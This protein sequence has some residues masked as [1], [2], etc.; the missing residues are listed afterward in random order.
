M[1]V[2]NTKNTLPVF[3][4]SIAYSNEEGFT[5]LT[6]IIQLFRWMKINA[7][8]EPIDIAGHN[9]QKKMKYGIDEG[10]LR[11][12]KQTNIFLHTPFDYVDFDKNT[13]MNADKYLD[14]AL[15]NYFIKSF[16]FQE[17]TNTFVPTTYMTSFFEKN[18]EYISNIDDY[19]FLIEDVMLQSNNETIVLNECNFCYSFGADYASFSL[20]KLDDKSIIGFVGEL[21]KVLNLQ[22]QA[23][24]LRNFHNISAAIME[25]KKTTVD[26]YVMVDEIKL[27]EPIVW[28]ETGIRL[29]YRLT[30]IETTLD[31]K[32]QISNL[33][34]AIKEGQIKLPDNCELWQ[35]ISDNVEY[36]PNIN[37]WEQ[38]VVNPNVI[39]RVVDGE[40]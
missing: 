26:A 11:H 12:L 37:F 18:R 8:F 6:N 13:Q 25:L 14:I 27:I 29:P 9:Y 3:R 36:Y 28:K 16:S 30:D 2:N 19:K 10:N 21:L 32:Y 33:V 39:L 24:F 20:N 38:V 22:K 23:A 31:G 7:I 40:N 34:G 15:Q 1:L 4:I 17:E 5:V 35:I